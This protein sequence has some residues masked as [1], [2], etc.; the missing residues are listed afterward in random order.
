[1]TP[2][3]KARIEKIAS[4]NVVELAAKRQARF[5]KLNLSHTFDLC[6]AIAASE[7]RGDIR[8]EFARRLRR[9]STESI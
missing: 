8:T 6:A 4:P 5:G 3:L 9:E 2:I 7:R 1:M